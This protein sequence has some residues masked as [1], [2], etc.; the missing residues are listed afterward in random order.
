MDIAAFS[1]PA[2]RL[3]RTPQD[4]LAFIPAELPLRISLE[5][6]LVYLLSEADRA[7]G[8]L[9]G[10]ASMLPNPRLL[11]A[12]LSQREAVLSSRIEG[13]QASVSDLALYEA[14]GEAAARSGDVRE[15]L[16]YR[17]AMDHG[18]E[19][20]ESLPLSLRLVRELHEI[21]M[22]DVRGQERTPGEFRTSQNW[23]GTPGA[24]LNEATYVPPPPSEL[25]ACLSDWE[26][27]LH[28]D[29][30]IP[31]IVRCAMMHYQF[32]AIHPFLDGNGRVGRLLIALFL[33]TAGHLPSPVLY[34]SPFFERHRDAYY[35]HLRAISERSLWNEWFEFFTRA[36]IVQCRDG[37]VRSR[38]MLALHEEYR[39]RL[40]QSKAPPSVQRLVEQLFASPATTVARAA[41]MLDLTPMTATRA[42]QVLVQ[43]G[44]LREVT[45][46]RR[47]RLYLA[48]EIVDAINAESESSD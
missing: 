35:R 6:E 36:V 17:R 37:L 42:I 33:C 14:A 10:M 41:M 16:N 22:Q 29:A 12:P 27:F 18:L 8:E 15:V 38:R 32:E 40:L 24:T 1:N 20:L 44:I 21:L 45:G 11:V 23:I 2:G 39:Q 26:R 13:T 48:D 4:Y 43:H 30:L 34:L 7:L 5:P 47:D 28:E 46:R 25:M 19:R 9:A 31:P 3:V